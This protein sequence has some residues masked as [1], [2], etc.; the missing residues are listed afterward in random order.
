MSLVIVIGALVVAGLLLTRVLEVVALSLVT[1]LAAALLI[2]LTFLVY[3][4]VGWVGAVAVV[5]AGVLLWRRAGSGP[6]PTGKF[7]YGPGD[8]MPPRP[9]GPDGRPL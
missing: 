8:T 9:K 3:A 2:G 7:G 1:L 5:G 6:P 4:A